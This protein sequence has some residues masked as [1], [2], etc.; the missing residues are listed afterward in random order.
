MRTSSFLPPLLIGLLGGWFFCSIIREPT[1]PSGNILT[2]TTTLIVGWWIQRSFR[3][4]AELDRVPLQTIAKLCERVDALITQCLAVDS[5]AAGSSGSSPVLLQT[6]RQLSNEISWLGTVARVLK[7]ATRDHGR[8]QRDYR[9]FKSRLS[10]GPPDL[11]RAG[12]VG[13]RMRTVTIQIQWLIS[14]RI[15]DDPGNVESLISPDDVDG[16]ND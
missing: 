8:L 14:Q 12:E 1:I 3:R 15:L 10:D 9:V 11:S 6:L 13:R 7:A 16:Q 4:Q 2:A 5:S